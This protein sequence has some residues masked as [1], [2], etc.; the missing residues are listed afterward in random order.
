MTF[1]LHAVSLL[2]S[3]LPFPFVDSMIMFYVYGFIGWIVEVVYYGVTEEKFINRGFL[4]GP[5][6]P[7]YG[8]GFYGVIWFFRRFIHNFPMLFFGSAFI[9]TFVELIAGVVL[10]KLFHMRWWDYSEYKYNF[11]G[12]ICLRFFVYWGLAC[13]LGMYMLHPAVMYI[14]EHMTYPIRYVVV[15]VLSAVLVIDIVVT[16]T[17]IFRLSDKVKFIGNISGGIR[18]VSDKLGSQIYDTVDNIVT[19]TSPAV[20]TTNKSYAEFREMYSK[21]REEEKELSRK[22][23]AEERELLGSYVDIGKQGLAR[24][25]DAAGAKIE[26]MIGT[27]KGSELRILTILRPGRGDDNDETIRYLQDQ[28]DDIRPTEATKK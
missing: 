16:V 7:V 20:A 25:K 18:L 15:A 14:I 22:H 21:H 11:H 10:Y 17:S 3:F 9:A 28:L 26:N 13:S 2:D 6:C 4:N 23:R 19:V 5:H 12:F 1:F 24:T 27:L 8:I